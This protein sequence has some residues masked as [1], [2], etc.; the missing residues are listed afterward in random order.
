MF[1]K[2]KRFLS[3]VQGEMGKVTWPTR[4]ELSSSTKIVLGL[5]L[6]LALFI[7]IVDYILAGIMDIVLI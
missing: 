3:D 1:T 2:I 7:F 4:E 6:V 5:S